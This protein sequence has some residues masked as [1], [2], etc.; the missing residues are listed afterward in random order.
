MIL[1]DIS[2]TPASSWRESVRRLLNNLLS[3]KGKVRIAL[4]IMVIGLVLSKSRMGNIAFFTSLLVAG[5]YYIVVGRRISRGIIGFFFSILLIDILTVGNIFGIHSVAEEIWQ[6]SVAT[7]TSRIDVG[8]DTLDMIRDYPLTGTGAGSFASTLPLY[9]S[10]NI[11]FWHYKYAHNDYLQFAVEFGLPGLAMLAGIVL[12]SL[13]H[14]A[15]AQ[16]I[17]HDQMTSGMGC[18]VLMAIVALLIHITV[19]FN[20]QIPANAATFVVILA[21]AW[22]TRWLADDDARTY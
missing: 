16:L 12:L 7:E 9:D 14:A 17:Q 22:H 1:A 13:W 6:T 19:D 21:L 15:R 10:G 3:D 11:G 2:T 8:R 5:G 4:I 20:L 18:G